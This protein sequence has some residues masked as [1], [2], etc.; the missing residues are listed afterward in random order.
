MKDPTDN[1]AIH[2]ACANG[3]FNE[4]SEMIFYGPV[5]QLF[6]TDN[7]FGNSP[8]HIV[9]G[10]GYIDRTSNKSKTITTSCYDLVDKMLRKVGTNRRSELLNQQNQRG[11]T[12]LHLA[13]L[14]H[15]KRMIALLEKHGASAV[16]QNNDKLTP[17]NMWKIYHENQEQFFFILDYTLYLPYSNDE[18][19]DWKKERLN[20][21]MTRFKKGGYTGFARLNQKELNQKE[22]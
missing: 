7:D 12:P 8:I 5:D 3:H 19:E 2:W 1:L 15:D 21:A 18:R 9:V 10:K 13:Y 20:K 4:V 17:K 16:I 6:N 11:N 14:R 22:L